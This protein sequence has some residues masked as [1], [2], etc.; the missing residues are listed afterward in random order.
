MFNCVGGMPKLS[1]V[2]MIEGAHLHD[3]AKSLRP[4]RKVGHLTV[5]TSARRRSDVRRSGGA[6]RERLVDAAWRR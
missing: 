5:T 6:G 1:D 2:I 4:G 3:Y